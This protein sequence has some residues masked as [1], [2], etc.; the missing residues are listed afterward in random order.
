MLPAPGLALQAALPPTL[1]GGGEVGDLD[2]RA[3]RA[4]RS[5]K[6]RAANP[7]TNTL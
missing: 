3:G 4:E 7:V 6:L 1:S 5:G 2:E